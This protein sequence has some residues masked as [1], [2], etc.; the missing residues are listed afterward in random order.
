[1]NTRKIYLP[2]TVTW[3]VSVWLSMLCLAYSGSIS[4]AQIDTAFGS[5]GFAFVEIA[6]DLPSHAGTA[7]AVQDD[8]K[9]V[10]GGFSADLTWPSGH[11]DGI[12]ARMNPDGSLDPTFGSA[13]ISVSSLDD[14]YPLNYGER[15]SIR[16]IAIDP[17]GRILWAGGQCV[18]R[19]LPDGSLDTSFGIQDP[20]SS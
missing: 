3:Q 11:V 17:L 7:I 5:S 16:D 12:I 6:N 10:A 9:I 18:S 8:G 19:L 20:R 4:N 13:G 1:M 15:T 14:V 2:T